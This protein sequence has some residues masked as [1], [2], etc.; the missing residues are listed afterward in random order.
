MKGG[1]RPDRQLRAGFLL[2]AAGVMSF[3][4]FLAAA[5]IL[6]KMLGLSV[7]WGLQFQNPF[8]LI[9]MIAVLVM[10][11]ANLFG[12]F[13]FALPDAL[14]QRLAAGTSR[15]GYFGDFA[16]GAFAAMPATPCSAPFLG[17]A[18]AFALAG[19]P[20]DILVI[21]T[22]LGL[23]LA[24]PY[25]CV[26]AMPGLVRLLPK[27]GPWMIWLKSLLGLLLAATA[28]WLVWVLAA[29]ASPITALI[30]TGLL[31]AALLLLGPWAAVVNGQLR[32]AL[33]GKMIFVALMTPL[34]FPDSTMET[35]P[36]AAAPA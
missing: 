5:T 24:L 29:V 11:A 3:I 9:A 34:A 20:L 6:A 25:F 16:T 35:A 28:A 21:F 8:F 10:F 26:A 23:G 30:A 17:T 33:T 2:S 27:P 14:T 22:A 4:W 18:I 19:Q 31:F 13:D 1:A 36:P 15:K 32:S 7:G 12:M